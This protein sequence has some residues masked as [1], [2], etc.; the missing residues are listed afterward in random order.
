MS[1]MYYTYNIQCVHITYRVFG[2]QSVK[3]TSQEGRLRFFAGE[4]KIQ[5]QF[6]PVH[7]PKT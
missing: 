3:T 5:H 2:A 7:P 4:T 6:H 1:Y